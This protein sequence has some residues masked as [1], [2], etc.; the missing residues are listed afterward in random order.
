MPTWQVIL[1]VFLIVL[2]VIVAVATLMRIRLQLYQALLL[3][4]EKRK[5]TV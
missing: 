5:A 4:A 3:E 2:Y 1:G